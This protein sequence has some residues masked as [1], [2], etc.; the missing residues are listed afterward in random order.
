MRVLNKI[1]FEAKDDAEALRLAAERLGKDAVILSTRPLRVG[2]FMGFFQRR[3][4]EVSAGILQ[5]D[6]AEEKSR[7][8]DKNKDDAVS[9]ER[10]V[11]FQKLLEFKQVSNEVGQ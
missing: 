9:K 10:L 11:A 5:D 6:R 8:K 7:E 3:V 2:G 4:L 1:T